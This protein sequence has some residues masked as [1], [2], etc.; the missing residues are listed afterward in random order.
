MN[1]YIAKSAEIAKTAHLVNSKV[2]SYCSI[3]ENTRFCYSSIQ[4]YSYVSVNS[5]IFSTDIGKFSSISWNVS[6]NPANHDYKRFTQHPILF[7]RKYGMLPNDTPF[8]SQYGKVEIG[9]DV[10]IGCNAII[11]GNVKIGDGAIIGANARISHDVPPY[12]IMI[13]NNH[14]LKDRFTSQVI[15]GLLELKWWDA[16]DEIIRDNIEI[17]SQAPTL[18]LCKKLSEIIYTTREI[19]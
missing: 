2:G 15:E 18:D 13:D 8:Y 7:A 6:V 11:L 10:W 16:P 3:G 14:H 17:L 12:A 19:E 1:N 5:N 4:D 9:N